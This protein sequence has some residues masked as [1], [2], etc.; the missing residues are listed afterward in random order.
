MGKLIGNSQSENFG[1]KLFL[2]K[3]IEYFDDNH[4]I[5]WNRQLF[6]RE[7]DVCI[8]IPE[9]GILVVE[10]KGWRQETVLRAEDD[11][12]IIQT[13]DGEKAEF[14]QK[15]ARGYRFSL[16]RHIRSSIGKTP[17]IFQMVGLP[18][19]TKAFYHEHKL[20]VPLEERFTFLKEDLDSN[21]AFFAKID[22]ALVEANNWSR[23]L[24]DDRTMLEIRNLFETGIDLS[25]ENEVPVHLTPL[26]SKE[27]FDYSRFYFFS[28]EQV[29]FAAA[30]QCAVTQYLLGC[31]LYCVFSCRQQMQLF[32]HAIDGALL[33]RGLLR[34]RDRIQINFDQSKSH[35]PGFSPIADTFSAFHC[36]F[37]V[38]SAPLESSPESFVIVN[39]NYSEEQKSV[40]KWLSQFCA[41]NV[42][43][44][45][46]EH[47]D[48]LKN[49]VIRAGAGTGKT[50]TMISRIAFVCY[51]QGVPLRQMA[52]RIVMITFTNEAA[53]QM[54]S[55]LKTYF[56]SCYLLTSR[57]DYLDIIACIDHMQI[58]TI[59]AYAKYLIAQL[60]SSFGYGVDVGIT[61]SQ[62]YRRRKISDLLDAYIQ[63]KT[64][65]YGK[66]YSDRISLP[67]YAIRDSILDFIL[68]LHNKSI[69]V[70]S[71]TATDFG[72][73]LPD[74][75]RREVHELLANVIP[76][77]E[78]QYSD[79]LRKNNRIHLS[80]MMS[81][82]YQFVSDEQ[83]HSR[84]RDLKR[85]KSAVQFLFVDEFQDTDD[86]QIEALLVLSKLLDYRMFV[87]GDIKQCIYR[88]RGAKEK[89]FDQLKME[90]HPDQWLQFSLR[91][92]YRTDRRLL[93]L[94]DR[95]FSAWGARDDELLTYLRES[96]RL[97]GSKDLNSYIHEKTQVAA[98][99]R[100]YHHIAISNEG[101]RMPAL[102]EEIKRLQERI[103]FEMIQRKEQLSPEEKRI[104]ILVRENWQADLVR[105]ECAKCRDNIKVQ[106]NTGGDLYMSQPALDMMTLVNALLHF[107]EADY[108][109]NLIT[110]NFFDIDIPKSVLYEK[111]AKIRSSGW[112]AKA[113]EKEQAD[114]IIRLMNKSLPDTPSD[115]KT[116]E[117]IVVALRTKPVLQVIREI[118]RTLEPWK[119]Y[120]PDDYAK[121]RYY[122]LNVDL[123]YEQ[124]ISACNIDRL[125]VNTLQEH[126]YNCITS[127]V[128][129]DSRDISA[130]TEDISIQCVTVHKAKGLEYGHVI[131]PFCSFP[132][133]YIKRSQLH[134]STERIENQTKIGYSLTIGDEAKPIRNDYYDEQIE[135]AE[136]SREETRILYVAMTRAIRSFSWID[137]QGKKSLSWQS[138]IDAEE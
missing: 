7:F 51:T 126:L 96:D 87:V 127:K 95:S 5:Y 47:A 59:H 80:N 86:T 110:S 24:F 19:I 45:F 12:I 91:R 43:Q 85:N 61:S 111:R 79:E 116:W 84:I 135:K 132:I 122:Q 29:D 52:D 65:E 131:L 8:L 39:G 44:Y 55:K 11:A 112:R 124:L 90:L 1:E 125:T 107:D 66:A 134:I 138:L 60:G 53:D 89:A 34:D 114:Y 62:F 118:Y 26:R 113:D 15:Q 82:L 17:L 120:A 22:Q 128:S 83:S 67:V 74:D 31:K 18:Q 109:Y 119:N 133:D 9:K 14:P 136:K 21:K 78:R 76:E 13:E 27:N 77:V 4:I 75:D 30:I 94:F 121:Q 57:E 72:A 71:I 93:D 46:V 20:D 56:R 36:S 6:G 99:R 25:A 2:S 40:L 92:N 41:F 35:S 108:L 104:A 117:Q 23:D 32:V 33:Q 137:L 130:E 103:R 115:D 16:Q 68:K 38:L 63:Q 3:A 48:P 54:E 28:P 106:T 101:M 64:K 50:Y 98:Q 69:N 42:E 88:F 70:A 37:S 105:I 100:Y 10:L 81:L 123:L 73:L 58:S 49:I 129:V 97:I 102:I